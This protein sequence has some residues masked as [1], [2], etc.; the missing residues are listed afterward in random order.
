MSTRVNRGRLLKL[1]SAGRLAMV[2]SRH[3]DDMHGESHGPPVE[4]PV[5]VMAPRIEGGSSLDDWQ[6]GYC[7]LR[8]YEFRTKS[9]TAYEGK[10][11]HVTLIIHGNSSVE[12]RVLA[13]GEAPPPPIPQDDPR[14]RGN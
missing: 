9:G 6:D 4:L 1:A 8:E 13:E 10:P 14:R 2:E 3:Y 11:G 12:F 5:R 7:N